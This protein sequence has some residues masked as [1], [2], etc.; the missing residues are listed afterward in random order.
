MVQEPGRA[1]IG[2]AAIIVMALLACGSGDATTAASSASAAS[3]APAPSAHPSAP[4]SADVDDETMGTFTCQDVKDDVC[5][6]PTDRFKVDTAVIHVSFRTK[7]LPKEGDV[8]N[9]KWIAED[10]GKAAKAN[11]VIASLDRKVGELPT[12]GMKSYFV[13]TQLSKPTKGFPAGK[14]RVEIRLA[15]DV[16]TTARFVVE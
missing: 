15:D 1:T 13:S 6:G 8:Y 14:Y 10:V 7:D 11:T 3:A 12:F 9:I 5:V 2:V 16:V 4:A